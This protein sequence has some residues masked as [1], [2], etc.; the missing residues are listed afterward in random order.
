LIWIY[1]AALISVQFIT[2]HGFI[3]EGFLTSS[4]F[5]YLSRDWL[6]RLS[7]LIMFS[8][9]FLLPMVLIFVFVMLAKKKMGRR[10]VNI[11][12]RLSGTNHRKSFYQS[13]LRA[14][15]SNISLRTT[16]NRD[17]SDLRRSISEAAISYR[18]QS[19]RV[20]FKCVQSQRNTFSYILK[21]E[22]RAM[23]TILLCVGMFLFAWLPYAVIVMCA[24]FAPSS[25]GYFLNPYTTTLPSVFAKV[26]SM[27]NPIIYTLSNRE[28]LNY[29]RRLFK[30]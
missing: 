18:Q 6:S 20:A 1:S 28:C 27:Y 26:S 12:N 16:V 23:K 25:I 15:S 5:D 29:F 30:T 19:S 4:S 21:R 13:A 24:Q 11:C 9:G 10:S 7:I 17:Q 8:F 22:A 3:L 2:P 14:T